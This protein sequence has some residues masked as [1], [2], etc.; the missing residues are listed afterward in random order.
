MVVIS[1]MVQ[2]Q[3]NS[4]SEDTRNLSSKLT[5]VTHDYPLRE[6]SAWTDEVLNHTKKLNCIKRL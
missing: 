2:L 4:A 5:Q 6:M 1:P 3:T